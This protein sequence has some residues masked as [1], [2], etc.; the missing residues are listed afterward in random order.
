M[1]ATSWD[2]KIDQEYRDT[3]DAERARRHKPP[4]NWCCYC[5]ARVHPRSVTC[6]H[7]RDLVALDGPEAKG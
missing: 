7:C 5:G 3:V 4:A 6:R 2:T 1:T